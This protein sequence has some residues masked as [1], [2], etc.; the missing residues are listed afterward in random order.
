M[1][2]MVQLSSLMFLSNTSAVLLPQILKIK[3]IPSG[4][5]MIIIILWYCTLFT[6]F[7]MFCYM[8]KSLGQLFTLVRK[9][10]SCQ[11]VTKVDVL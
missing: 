2:K 9:A 4:F 5:F 3:V 8:Q 6:P 1:V 11:K 10:L 7:Q